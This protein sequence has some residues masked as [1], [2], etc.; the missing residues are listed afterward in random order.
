MDHADREDERNSEMNRIEKRV[1]S[2]SAGWR[3]GVTGWQG[4]RKRKGRRGSDLQ[5]QQG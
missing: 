2:S 1:V 5:C 3:D 4:G